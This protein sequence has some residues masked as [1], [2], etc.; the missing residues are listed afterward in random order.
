MSEMPCKI[1]TIEFELILRVNGE[2]NRI[3]VILYGINVFTHLKDGIKE[4]LM[5]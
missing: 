3:D 4:P 5:P 1:V 2:V